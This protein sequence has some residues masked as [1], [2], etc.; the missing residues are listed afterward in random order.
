[1]IYLN[2]IRAEGY[3]KLRPRIGTQTVPFALPAGIALSMFRIFPPS[4]TTGADAAVPEAVV[5]H[6]GSAASGTLLRRPFTKRQVFRAFNLSSPF[7][8]RTNYH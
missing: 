5:S 6:T 8:I 3:L 4:L 7:A 2:L 1:V